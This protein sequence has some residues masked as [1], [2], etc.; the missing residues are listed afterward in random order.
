[1]LIEKTLD[2]L[3]V[4]AKSLGHCL[5]HRIVATA[6]RH[7]VEQ[8]V[9]RGLFR[10]VAVG[11]DRLFQVCLIDFTDRDR[12]LIEPRLE[13]VLGFSDELACLVVNQRHSLVAARDPNASDLLVRFELKL[14]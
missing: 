8:E 14:P 5:L 12:V 11:R 13:D 4:R 9:E 2:A 7:C 10:H 1:M 3:V 6:V